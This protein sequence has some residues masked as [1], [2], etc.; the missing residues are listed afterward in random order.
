MDRLFAI[1]Q[2]LN[3]DHWWDGSDSEDK[4][5]KDDRWTLLQPFH[6]KDN[7][8]EMSTYTSDECRD[9]TKLNYTYDDLDDAASGA[10]KTDGSGMLDEE[11][12]TAAL[13]RRMNE[14]YPGSANV[15]ATMKKDPVLQVPVGLMPSRDDIIG[16]EPTPWND[17]IINVLY[18]RYA[19]QGA[20]YS[21]EFYLGGPKA[22]RKTTFHP[23]NFVGRVYT[24]SNGQGESCPN[25]TSQETAGILSRGQVP[26]TL[27]LLH[28]AI[29]S[30]DDHSLDPSADDGV[31]E[32]L[33]NHLQWRFVR[34]GGE[35][36]SASLFS[37]TRVTVLRGSGELRGP[38]KE[39]L[40]GSGDHVPVYRNYSALPHITAGKA[41]GVHPEDG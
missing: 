20:A 30:V 23:R 34:F 22:R 38:D 31:E 25:C 39:Y 16:G 32:Y 2:C 24:F 33:K 7:D 40:R 18:D 14:M 28:H 35:V 21:I 15:L 10:L 26:L 11:K 8:P 9:F 27:H 37:K 3:W 29:D 13:R 12:Y 5:G 6:M 1:W 36:V 4:G 41:W 19:L 17:F